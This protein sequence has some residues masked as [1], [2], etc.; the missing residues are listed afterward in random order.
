[1]LQDQHVVLM[2]QDGVVGEGLSLFLYFIAVIPHAD[3]PVLMMFTAV[4]KDMQAV[5]HAVDD[6]QK[7]QMLASMSICDSSGIRMDCKMVGDMQ[8]DTGHD[9]RLVPGQCL[10]A[11]QLTPV[12]CGTICAMASLVRLNISLLF[13]NSCRLINIHLVW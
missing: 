5:L 9:A 13:L 10:M 1:M 7:L 2:V 4:C 6:T 11:Q 12:A 8:A 3:E